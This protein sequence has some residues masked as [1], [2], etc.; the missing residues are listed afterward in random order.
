MTTP[1]L[2]GAVGLAL[3]CI[4]LLLRQRRR[5]DLLFILGGIGLET[6]SIAIKDPI[7]II[8]QLAFICSAPYDLIRHR[9]VKAT[10]PPV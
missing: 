1:R 4:G 10:A 9:R 8:L 7:F 5:Q 6:Y 3:I 2:I